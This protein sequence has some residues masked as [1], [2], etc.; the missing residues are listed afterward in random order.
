MTSVWPPERGAFIQECTCIF[1]CKHEWQSPLT[2]K[3][4]PPCNTPVWPKIQSSCCAGKGFY[5]IFKE[6]YKYFIYSTLCF[7]IVLNS[8]FILFPKVLLYNL[9][10]MICY[11][12]LFYLV[13]FFMFRS[14]YLPSL[15]IMMSAWQQTLHFLKS[16][17]RCRV[18]SLR[19]IIKS[20]TLASL[21][22]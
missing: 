16:L 15:K 3:R 20:L 18:C 9:V 1:K 13:I 21:H 12:K 2:W 7:L 10:Y 17:L 8:Y 22:F 19:L 11:V 4:I 14:I 5:S 6:N